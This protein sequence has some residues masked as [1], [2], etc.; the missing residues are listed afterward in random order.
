M[1]LLGQALDADLHL[2]MAA[3]G[4][5]QVAE[6][7]GQP[8]EDVEA[9]RQQEIP[10]Q[11]ADRLDGEGRR[12]LKP[13]LDLLPVLRAGDVLDPQPVADVPPCR[14][15]KG[16]AHVALVEAGRAREDL[17]AERPADAPG[18]AD[19]G[20]GRLEGGDGLGDRLRLRVVFGDDLREAPAQGGGRVDGLALS[21]PGV[22]DHAPTSEKT[23]RCGPDQS[24]GGSGATPRTSMRKRDCRVRRWPASLR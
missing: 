23:S 3:I 8:F 9:R 11:V 16:G 14:F 6:A 15:E 7:F 4:G 24:P 21:D 18:H 12:V 13:K 17:T 20:L 19:S 1:I 2:G 10:E 5:V 22:A